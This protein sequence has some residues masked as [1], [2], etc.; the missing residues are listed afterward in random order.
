MSHQTIP[1]EGLRSFFDRFQALSAASDVE[2]LAAMYAESVTI[3]GATGALVVKSADLRRAIPKRKALLESAGCTDTALVAFE[4]TVLGDRYSLVRA[5]FRWLFE[6][7]GQRDAIT[8]PA[9]F[10]VDRGGGSPQ[11]VFYLNERDVFSVL[12]ERGVLPAAS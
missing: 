2:A 6:D 3:A 11:I 5:Q 10:V 8:L 4:E 12:R 7:S 1:T 9:S